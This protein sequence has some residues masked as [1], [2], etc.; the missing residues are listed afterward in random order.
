MTGMRTLRQYASRSTNVRHHRMQ[1]DVTLPTLWRGVC[2]RCGM[3]VT[4]TS[5]PAPHEIAIG[6][7]AVALNC[8]KGRKKHAHRT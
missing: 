6:G 5:R 8:K 7:E 2:R 3:E 4:I 1:W